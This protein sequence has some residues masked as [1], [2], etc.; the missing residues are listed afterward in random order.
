MAR[1]SVIWTCT[2]FHHLLAQIRTPLKCTP[3][4]APRHYTVEQTPSL[5]KPPRGKVR[6]GVSAPH[7]H[8]QHVSDSGF[9]VFSQHECE[10]VSDPETL[11]ILGSGS[12]SL[13]C[14]ACTTSA[15]STHKLPLS[16]TNTAIIQSLLP[17]W[18]CTVLLNM[19]LLSYLLFFFLTALCSFLRSSFQT[20]SILEQRLTLT[21]NKLKECVDNQ[22]EIVFQLRRREEA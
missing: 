1:F 11:V 7:T 5:W 19:L 3:P 4:V 2:I 8:G 13:D 15:S 6:H 21:E 18:C 16:H 10:R 20:V 17:A 22:E 9:F 14:V 12:R